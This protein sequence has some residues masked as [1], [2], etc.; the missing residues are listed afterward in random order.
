MILD[1]ISIAVASFVSLAF[2]GTV[3]YLRMGKRKDE[4]HFDVWAK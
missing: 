4:H 1:Q 3:H 2:A